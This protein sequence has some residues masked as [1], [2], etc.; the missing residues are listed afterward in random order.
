MT[1]ETDILIGVSAIDVN[2]VLIENI[3]LTI[4]LII[5]TLYCFLGTGYHDKNF[6]NNKSE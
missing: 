1:M 3:D 2:I 5:K 4:N 6:I